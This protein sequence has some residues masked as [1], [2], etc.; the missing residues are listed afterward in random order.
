MDS[1][2][3]TALALAAMFALIS[4]SSPWFEITAA[5]TYTEGPEREPTIRTQYSIDNEQ[6]TFELSIDNATPLLLYWIQREDVNQQEQQE[7]QNPTPPSKPEQE[8]ATEQEQTDEPCSGSCLDR[9]RNV[10]A[11]SMA[12]TLAALWAA[13][14]RPNIMTR[15]GAP[16]AWLF[17]LVVI[18][19]GVPLSAAVDFGIS[20]GDEGSGG[21]SS[22]GGF[23]SETQ[24]SVSVDQ[25]AHFS[26][27]SGSGIS[28]DG[29]FFTYDSVG[30][31]L[32]LLEE[33]DRQAVIEDPPKRGEQGYESLVRFHGELVAGPGSIVS[34]WFL[35]LPLAVFVVTS[36]SQSEEEE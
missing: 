16:T 5:G 18:L 27:D 31:D 6:Q 11:A 30:Y 20:G 7:Q 10:V 8:Q 26:S 25:F 19:A 24:D 2:R 36:K 4:W 22:T 17:C 21:E 35:I 1:T 33:G 32:G 14:A 29:I 13:A 23:D 34:W 9:A 15:I 12:V 28:L 3:F